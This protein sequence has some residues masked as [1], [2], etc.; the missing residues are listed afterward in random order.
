M[1]ARSSGRLFN[2]DPAESHAIITKIIDL[3]APEVLKHWKKQ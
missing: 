2:R 1:F 3:R